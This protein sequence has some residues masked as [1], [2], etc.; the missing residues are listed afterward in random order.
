MLVTTGTTFKTTISKFSLSTGNAAE[1]QGFPRETFKLMP[2]EEDALIIVGDEGGDK[3]EVEIS[4]LVD[5]DDDREEDEQELESLSEIV[6]S[7][8]NEDIATNDLKLTSN[9]KTWKFSR[10]K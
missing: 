2:A 6:I 3:S 7:E 8:H 4:D 5:G 1:P 9:F 10:S